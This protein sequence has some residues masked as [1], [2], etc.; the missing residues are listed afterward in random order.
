[1]IELASPS[2]TTLGRLLFA[3]LGENAMVISAGDTRI[4]K[5]NKDE[6]GVSQRA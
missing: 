5:A 4:N 2:C 1:M 3:E 6:L